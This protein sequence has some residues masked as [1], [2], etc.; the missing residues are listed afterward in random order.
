MVLPGHRCRPWLF[1]LKTI[2]ALVASFCFDRIALRHL[3]DCYT[4]KNFETV[5]VMDNNGDQQQPTATR[6]GDQPVLRGS[7]AEVL[8]GPQTDATMTVTQAA[9]VPPTETESKRQKKDK[10]TLATLDLTALPEGFKAGITNPADSLA[11]T[12]DVRAVEALVT[13]HHRAVTLY[14]ELLEAQEARLVGLESALPA[15]QANS[16]AAGKMATL[17]SQGADAAGVRVEACDGRVTTLTEQLNAFAERLT[18]SK[19]EQE[20]ALAQ[21]LQTIEG[22]FKQCDAML[23][24]VKISMSAAGAASAMPASGTL[25]MPHQE[26]AALRSHVDSL[27]AVIQATG[28]QAKDAEDAT[29]LHRIQVNELTAWCNTSS[30]VQS[31]AMGAVDS[32]LRAELGAEFASVKEKIRIIEESLSKPDARSLQPSQGAERFDLSSGLRDVLEGEATPAKTPFLNRGLWTGTGG[33][34]GPGGGGD[35]PGDDGDDGDDDDGYDDEDTR[36]PRRGRHHD[37]S[38][39]PLSRESKNPFDSKGKDDVDKY[40][41]KENKLWRKKTTNYLASRLPDV[42]P[43]I[44][45]AER[46]KEAITAE[47]LE[48]ACFVDPAL[49][50]IRMTAERATIISFHLWGFLNAKLVDDAWDLLDSAAMWDGLEVWRLINMDVTQLTQAEVMNLEDAVLMPRRLK[51][52]TDIPKGLVAWDAAHRAFRDAGGTPLDD[53]RQVGALMRLLP[54]TVREKALWEWEKFEGKPLALRRWVRERTKLLVNWED[55]GHK[56]VHLL[57]ERGESDDESPELEELNS[58]L[59]HLRER[60]TI[61]REELHAFYRRKQSAAA[62]NR[63]PNNGRRQPSSRPAREAPARDSRDTKCPNCGKTRHSSQECNSPKVELKDRPC[64]ECGETGHVALKCPKK[65]KNGQTRAL[66]AEAIPPVVDFHLFETVGPSAKANSLKVATEGAASRRPRPQGTTVGDYIQSAFTR[67]AVKEASE[68]FDK[69]VTPTAAMKI[70]KRREPTRFLGTHA[71]GCSCCPVKTETEPLLQPSTATGPREHEADVI[72][73]AEIPLS[74]SESAASLTT[75]W[76]RT[77]PRSTTAPLP[78]PSSP[79]GTELLNQHAENA[80]NLFFETEQLNALPVAAEPEWLEIECCLDTGSSV[81]AINRLEIPGCEI[82]ESPGSRV[83][84]QFQAAGGGLIDN[85]G[86]ALLT[87]IPHDED[88]PNAVN[89]NMQVAAVTRPL[90]S[91]PKLTEG[92]KL[93]VTCMEKEAHVLTA[94][95]KLV[96]RFKKKQGLYVCT[97]KIKN[98]RWTPFAGPA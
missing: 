45:W 48:T 43:L 82:T 98:P 91:V 86:Q 72:K 1:W 60:G 70:Q 46:Q 97:M 64:W 15:A 89:I 51:L 29:V 33:G 78:Q 68:V 5:N 2:Q 69:A 41:G 23:K 55:A 20:Q 12:R 63:Q 96:A 85:E 75:S 87:M 47:K 83:G 36:R 49:Q 4:S 58:F 73:V 16:V 62:G 66:Q 92:D 21:H 42:H 32:K 77:T 74:Q 17:A 39:R 53:H 13:K 35:G 14:K 44:L 93:K 9:V 94:Q 22:T 57:D 6:P 34:G 24:D 27:A 26:L 95:N 37:S 30:R 19:G 7:A 11:V 18:V 3:P 81:H 8:A 40:N 25:D 84:Q 88:T 61:T 65:P 56:A 90:I 10:I 54:S 38:E 79:H 28:V 31:E 71:A 52:L 59:P 80:I 50:L 76:P 67:L